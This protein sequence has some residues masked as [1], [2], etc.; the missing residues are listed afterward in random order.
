MRPEDGGIHAPARRDQVALDAFP[1][2]DLGR[3]V[4]LVALADLVGRLDEASRRR[5]VPRHGHLEDAA[6]GHR[7]LLLDEALA[8]RPAADQVGA[9]VVLQRA[10]DDLAGTRRVLVDQHDHRAALVD[11]ARGGAV[12]TAVGWVAA[13]GVDDHL[14]RAQEL[15][16]DL[17]G[18]VEQAA[19]V[20][21]EVEHEARHALALQVADGVAD[22]V[23]A[24]PR[25]A[26]QLDQARLVID[27]VGRDNR[28]QRNPVADDAVVERLPVAGSLHDDVHGRAA[29]PLEAALH[30]VGVDADRGLAVDLDDAVARLE[31]RLVARPTRDGHQHDQRVGLRAPFDELVVDADALEAGVEA[32]TD[33][34]HLVGRD[35]DR[36]GVEPCEHALDGILGQLRRVDLLDVGPRDVLVGLLDLAELLHLLG[37]GD[38]VLDLDADEEADGQKAGAEK[39]SQADAGHS[40]RRVRMPA[41]RT[42]AGVGASTVEHRGGSSF[43]HKI[44]ARGNPRRDGIGAERRRAE[45]ARGPEPFPALR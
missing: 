2:F 29:R 3:E 1:E 35:V 11:A 45:Q 19:R 42:E 41:Q 16:G 25:E 36:M 30:A 44:G 6:V 31:A 20:A 37:A 23:V 40:V 4:V 14:A 38:G 9:V 21:A 26:L 8:E 10:R 15:V 22:L 24:G 32:L 12:L 33:A 17:V 18:L 27:H 5:V 34:A 7:E 39:G 43:V 28:V 13:L